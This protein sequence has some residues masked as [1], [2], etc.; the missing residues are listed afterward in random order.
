LPLVGAVSVDA[1]SLPV[2]T[3][4]I[5]SLDAFNP[6]AFFVLMFLLSLMVHARSRKRMMIVGGVFVLFSGL[7]YFLFMSAW[8]NVFLWLGELRMITL[9]AGI[10]AIVLALVNI[11]DYFRFKQG[12]SLSIPD[13]AKPGL[14]ARMRG[15]VSADSLPAM[16]GGTVL[17]ALAANSY[18]LLCTTGFPMVYTRA[19]TLNE[20]STGA[21]YGYL[22]AYNAIYVLPLLIIVALFAFK[23]GSRKLSEKEGRVLK[24]VSGVMMLLL[25]V[26]LVFAPTALSNPVVAVALVL[27]AVSAGA[28]G[29]WYGERVEKVAKG[30]RTPYTGKSGKAKPV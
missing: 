3:V 10:L 25:G 17:L 16:V 18:E 13:S 5:A 2:L 24:M 22:A 26:L 7:I 20:L 30:K 12:V 28:A 27:V 1:L 11:K 29:Y 6:C 21:Y 23:F 15:L 9:A 14:F 8:L 4:A 19:L